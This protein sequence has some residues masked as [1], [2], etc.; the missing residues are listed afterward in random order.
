MANI[1]FQKRVFLRCT[2]DR[3]QS[4]EDQDAK[5]LTSASKAFDTFTFEFPIPSNIG[6]EVSNCLVQVFSLIHLLL[7]VFQVE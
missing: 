7:N 6:M 3:W 2:A 5:F 1:A 4:F